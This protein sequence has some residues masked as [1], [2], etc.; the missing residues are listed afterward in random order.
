MFRRRSDSIK[1]HSTYLWTRC[2]LNTRMEDQGCPELA[3]NWR[4]NQCELM[5]IRNH[6]LG[7]VPNLPPPETSPVSEAHCPSLYCVSVMSKFFK[8][9]K[10][11]YERKFKSFDIHFFFFLVVF[12]SLPAPSKMITQVVRYFAD[13]SYLS[14]V[15][16]PR[17]HK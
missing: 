2:S 11:I 15:E 8:I 16:K 9:K 17:H 14:L 7:S 13:E 12:D 6:S 4:R 10:N 3:L 5:Q 1:T